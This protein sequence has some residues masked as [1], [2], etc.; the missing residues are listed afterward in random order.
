[1]KLIIVHNTVPIPLAVVKG[2]NVSVQMI[3]SAQVTGPVSWGSKLVTKKA[4]LISSDTIVLE[5]IS[6]AMFI[7]RFLAIHELKDKFAAGAISG[8]PFKMYWTG[9]VYGLL[10]FVNF[11]S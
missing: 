1:M 11:V 8:P 4:K 3:Y 10:N 6:Y 7:K 5:D 9:S 2:H